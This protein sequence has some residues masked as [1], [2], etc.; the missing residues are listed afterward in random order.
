MNNISPLEQISG[1][2]SLDANL[3]LHQHKLDSMARFMEIKS[4]NPKMK[5]KEVGK[6]LGYSSSTLQR[7]RNDIKMQSSYKLNNPKSSP[8]TSNDLKTPQKTKM[9]NLFLKK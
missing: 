6:E 7:Y 3:I 5:Q 2:G 4:I 9:I 8:K 1:T